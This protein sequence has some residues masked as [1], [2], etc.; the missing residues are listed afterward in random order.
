MGKKNNIACDIC[1]KKVKRSKIRQLEV[2]KTPYSRKPKII[3]LCS[4]KCEFN[5]TNTYQ[6][7]H[8]CGRWIKNP[9]GE[10]KTNFQVTVDGYP[11]CWKCWEKMDFDQF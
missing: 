4:E 11:V 10:R 3:K 1:G 5:L 6:R 8:E 2:Y 9:E 7:C